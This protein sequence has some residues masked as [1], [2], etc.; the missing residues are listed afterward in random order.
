MATQQELFPKNS[1]TSISPVVDSL[2]R[3]L[4]SQEKEGDL[5]TLEA[6][7]SLKSQGF[8]PL[9]DLNYCSW[10]TSK[11]FSATITGEP[12]E[13]SSQPFLSWGIFANGRYLTARISESPKTENGCSLSDILEKEVDKKYFLSKK[14]AK[15]I[16]RR[17]KEQLS[18]EE[19]EMLLDVSTQEEPMPLTGQTLID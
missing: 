7:Y 15:G 11:D 12:L 10:K 17:Y 4:V 16:L 13:Q 9:K 14:A 3:H 18:E 1:Q 2:A 19:I 6:L 5:R 8:Y